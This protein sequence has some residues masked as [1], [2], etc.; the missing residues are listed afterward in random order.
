MRIRQ[1]TF[2]R[3][4]KIGGNRGR[5]SSLKDKF[6]SLSLSLWGAAVAAAARNKK[7]LLG[8]LLF[9][10]IVAVIVAEIMI[11]V[12]EIVAPGLFRW[13]AEMK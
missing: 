13:W 8:A 12:R 4:L 3:S 1:G 7:S 11:T 9:F 2:G 6:F 5:A 10:I